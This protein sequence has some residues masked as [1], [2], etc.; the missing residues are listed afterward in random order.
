MT[1]LVTVI[2]HDRS[3]GVRGAAN[4]IVARRIWPA[5]ETLPAGTG[6]NNQV[7]IGLMVLPVHN[8]QISEVRRIKATPDCS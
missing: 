1:H 2:N 8:K 6:T 4:I 3:R 5:V 7:T